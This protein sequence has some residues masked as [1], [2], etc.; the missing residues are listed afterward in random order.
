MG[1]CIPRAGDW[2]QNKG[3]S[4]LLRYTVDRS[5]VLREQEA[6]EGDASDWARANVQYRSVATSPPRG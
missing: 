4:D 6:G 3:T 2:E 5:A 1:A